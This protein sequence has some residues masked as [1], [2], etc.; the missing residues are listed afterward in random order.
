MSKA[1][2]FM[3][4]LFYFEDFDCGKIFTITLEIDTLCFRVDNKDDCSG[5]KI[6]IMI[7]NFVKFCYYRIVHK[8]F[9]DN[10][11]NQNKVSSY[12]K[13]KMWKQYQ[14]KYIQFTTMSIFQIR[15]K[16]CT[17]KIL[18]KHKQKNL[19]TMFITATSFKNK[20][21]FYINF[22]WALLLVV[23]S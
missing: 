13:W 8:F 5:R 2:F 17:N 3:M 7:I 14:R 16:T 12:A 9:A 19:N 18:I 11:K 4:C 15:P 1:N 20:Y 10:E 22:M 6:F 21:K 23:C